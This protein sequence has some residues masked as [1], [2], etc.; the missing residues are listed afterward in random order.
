MHGGRWDEHRLEQ[1]HRA[2]V[3]GRGGRG[4]R[5]RNDRTHAYGE[6]HAGRG[7]RGCN[8]EQGGK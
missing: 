1:Q 7:S 2:L 6:D 8:T 4:D 5:H 3:R